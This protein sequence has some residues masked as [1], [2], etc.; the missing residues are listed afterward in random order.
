MK[1]YMQPKSG[2]LRTNPSI[3]TTSSPNP[4]PFKQRSSRRQKENAA[5]PDP[6][7]LPDSA[8]SPSLAAAKSAPTGKSRSPLPPRP[9]SSNSNPLK[10]KLNME[11]V[12]ENGVIGTSDSGVKVIVRIRPPNKEEEDGE[13]M[14]QN[15]SS[16]SFSFLGQTFTFDSVADNGATQQDIF[17]LVGAPL[18]ENC[19]AGFNSSIFAYGQTGSGK[20]YTMCG[21]ANALLEEN[22]SSKQGLTP[23]V[24]EKLFARINE[25]QI[26]HAEKQLKYQCRC[27]FLEIYNE[28]ITDLLDPNQK[29]LQIREDVKTGVYV[30]NLTEEYVGTMKDVKLLLIKGLS[31]RRTGATSINAESSR[32][33][34]VFTCVVESRCKSMADGLSSFRTSRINLVD[35]AG[36]ERQKLTG[37]AGERLKEAG[38]I[39]RSLSQLGNLINIL[40]EVSQTGKQRHIPYRDSR[41]T[42][43]L[44]E[45]LGGNAKLAMIC[46]ISLAESCKSET[47]STLRFA[48]RA[49]AIKNKAVV[50]EVMQDDVNVLREVIRQLKDELL[51][52]KANGNSTNTNGGYSTGWNA[53]RSLNLLKFS[54]NRPMKLPHIEDDSDEEMEI[55]EEAVERLCIQVGLQSAGF[56]ENN[57]NDSRNLKTCQSDSKVEAH[58]ES[59]L[60]EEKQI[61]TLEIGCGNDQGYEEI[62]VHMQDCQLEEM[63][64]E[65][66]NKHEVVDGCREHLLQAPSSPKLDGLNHQSHAENS[67]TEGSTG[68]PNQE[69]LFASS[70]CK[71][72]KVSPGKVDETKSSADISVGGGLD[73]FIA[74][75]SHNSPT[76]SPNSVLPFNI[77]IVPSENSPVY[78]SPTLSVS[79]RVNNSSRKGL[80]TTSMLSA[81]QKNLR[82]SNSLGPEVLQLSLAPPSTKTSKNSLSPTEYLAASL[83]HGL[84]VIDS[85]IQSSALRRSSFRFSCKPVDMKPLLP[86]D[87]VDVGVQ[88][89]FQD[90]ETLQ[91][92]S[93][94]FLCSKCM[95]RDSQVESKEANDC[96]GLQLVPVDGSDSAENSRMQV[97]KAVE[98]VLAGAIRREMA[99]EEF[100]SKQATEI[101]QLNRLVQQYKHERECNT[102]IEQMREDKIIRLESL[103]DNILPTEEFMEQELVS[104]MHEHKLLKDKYEN[105]PEVLRTKIELK[106]VQDELDTYRNF[107]DMGE[108]DVLLEEIQHLKSQLQYYIYSSPLP[109]RKQ[110]PLLQLTYPCEP[111]S[112]P[113]C[114][115]PELNEENANERSEQEKH[116]SLCILETTEESVKEKFEQERRCWIEAESKWISLSDE[117]RI[118]LEASRSI[119]EKQKQELDAEKRCCEELKEALQMAMQGHAHILEQLAELEERHIALLARH[120]KIQ[121]GVGDVKKAAAKAGVKGAESRFINSLA[122][123]ISTLKVE[124][125]R[126]IRYL[127]E[128]NKGLQAQL[129]DTAEAVQAAGELLVRLKE[130]EEA[131][132]ISQ[133]RAIEAEY[134]AEKAYKQ[135]DKLKKTQETEITSMNQLF[136]ESPLPKEVS[137]P[138]YDDSNLMRYD[139][140]E[141]LSGADDQKWRKE[142]VPFHHG[143][144]GEL[145]KLAEPSWFSGYDRCNV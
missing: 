124:R 62:D 140:G 46:A 67:N 73:I 129:R 26:K 130:A 133:K 5:P 95:S 74:D 134:K 8:L 123:E 102:I 120:R 24:F 41:L 81:S 11:T 14:V 98:K 86:V 9:P 77:S 112:A 103:M 104:F 111:T 20:T 114:V 64:S 100:S 127:R 145:S 128:E 12:F 42:F 6:N 3:E 27:S 91:V 141:S 30:E 72:S 34:S 70:D 80:T 88:A 139:G 7:A 108:R 136:E 38:N 90:P 125:E 143:E 60:G 92:D 29:N 4:S 84:Q 37:A 113:L 119:A 52:M 35:L 19:L 50:N 116:Q 21:P 101:R 109:A 2:I 107:F 115:I 121:E 97:P 1:S 106:R 76:S 82:E 33:H 126:E 55:D 99:L 85:H 48:Q 118:E 10:R 36:S 96:L 79:P 49:K 138:V 59:I 22:L 54:L 63:V 132:A 65:E 131:S 144:D 40:A 68:Q 142:F 83:H 137:R 39:N 57:I 69:K 31:N 17:Q 94:A 105:H 13:L 44:Q 23:R 66:F 78:Q 56:E 122:A 47:L 75:P 61:D 135:I 89:L 93:S 45:S 53:R 43:L 87:K 71:L 51:Q 32:S 16:D 18:V 110:S 15:I 25:E 117:L 58:K 28:H